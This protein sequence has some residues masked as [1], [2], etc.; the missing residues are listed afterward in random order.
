MAVPR[1]PQTPA[2]SNPCSIKPLQHQTP[3]AID[4]CSNANNSVATMWSE[5]LLVID[6]ASLWF[7]KKCLLI[8]I[9]TQ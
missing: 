3:A 5:C 6:C 2:A 9:N 1:Q 7:V 8:T 4:L